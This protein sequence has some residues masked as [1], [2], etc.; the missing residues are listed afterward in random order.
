MRIALLHDYLNQYGGAERVLDALLEM[1][2]EADIYTL[3]YDEVK[4]D[5]KYKERIRGTSMLDIP[6]V[7]KNHRRWIPLFPFATKTIRSSTRYD[8]V[9]SSSSGYA[10]A[11]PIRGKRHVCYC[12]TPLRY[13]WDASYLEHHVR[14]PWFLKKLGSIWREVYLKPWDKKTALRP[15]VFLANSRYI[16]EK[17]KQWYGRDAEVV[18]PPVSAEWF[19]YDADVSQ[20]EY[21][22]MVGRLL[23][24]KRFDIGI[25]ACETIK[26]KLKIVG[27]GPEY[28]RLKKEANPSL[29]EC[30]GRASD[31]ELRK[32]YA[33]ARALLFPQVEDFGLVAAEAQASGLPVIAYNRGGAKEIVEH[34]KT[35]VLFEEQ[36]EQGLTRAME[37]FERMNFD[38]RFIAEQAGRF[39]KSV[40]KDKMKA[41]IHRYAGSSETK[42]Y[43]GLG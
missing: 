31:V 19:S 21:Y 20:K 18:E 38:R 37:E 3:L 35:G 5:G 7:R 30:M 27:I 39:S 43:S 16:A 28:E 4:L 14:A 10:K 15:D 12:H 29:V 17:V 36:S 24:Y 6:F 32:Y 23:S 9:L 42:H 13:A 2:P 34:G 25:R 11:F 41:I 40:F 26:K 22:L 1:F 8:I 33:E